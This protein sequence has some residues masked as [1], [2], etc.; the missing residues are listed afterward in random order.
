M[1]ARAIRN[2][3]TLDPSRRDKSAEVSESTILGWTQ[4]LMTVWY[5]MEIAPGV[6]SYHLN[7]VQMIG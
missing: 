3:A 5:D 4:I 2:L 6:A 1:V 7:V